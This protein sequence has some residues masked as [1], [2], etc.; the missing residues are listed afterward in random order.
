M[1]E[2]AEIPPHPKGGKLYMRDVLKAP[3]TIHISRNLDSSAEDQSKI[4]SQVSKLNLANI[5]VASC[6]NRPADPDTTPRRDE[7]MS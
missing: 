7:V 5:S 4:L 6:I 2:D 1:I 3:F